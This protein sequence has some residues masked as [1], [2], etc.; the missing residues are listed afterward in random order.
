[1]AYDDDDGGDGENLV[2]EVMVTEIEQHIHLHQHWDQQWY[3]RGY[4][5]G[6]SVDTDVGQYQKLVRVRVLMKV[7]EQQK[8]AQKILCNDDDVYDTTTKVDMSP[9]GH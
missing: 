9:N 1:M 8:V 2:R 4:R 3:E 5:F 7:H 6:S